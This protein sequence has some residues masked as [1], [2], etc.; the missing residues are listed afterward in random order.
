[1]DQAYP[2]STRYSI[3]QIAQEL[4]DGW[5]KELG[6]KFGIQNFLA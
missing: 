6:L 3:V 1:L 2:I 5:T 4:G